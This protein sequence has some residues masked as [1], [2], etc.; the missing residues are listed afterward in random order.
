MCEVKQGMC[1]TWA[2]CYQ[3]QNGTKA[4]LHVAN[5][6]KANDAQANAKQANT[7]LASAN[8]AF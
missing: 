1:G 5:V 2:M 8:F 6:V 3:G 7:I 4:K